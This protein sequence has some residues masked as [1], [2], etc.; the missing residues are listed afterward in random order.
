MTPSTISQPVNNVSLLPQPGGGFVLKQ[1]V[2]FNGGDALIGFSA[3]AWSSQPGP[4]SMRLWLDQQPTPGILTLY[5][6]AGQMHLALGRTWVWCQGVS[7]GEHTIMLE[8]GDTTVTD[9]NDIACVTVWEMGDGCAVRMAEDAQCPAGTGAGLIQATAETTGGQLLISGSTSGWVTQAGGFVT[10]WMP[11]DGGDPVEMQVCANNA[12]Q[13]LAIVP[14]DMVVTGAAE[15]NHEVQ[16]NADGLT[17]TDG[18]DTA[19]LSVVEW[20]NPADAPVIQPINPPLQN[21]P[22]AQ[23]SG[24]G[25]V[26]TDGQFSTNGGTLLI[27]TAVSCWTGSTGVPLYM[28]IQVDGTSVGFTQIWANFAT[29]HMAMVT[30]DL[31]V[32]GV[33][34]G[35]HSL[36]LMAENG[37]NTDQND[38][39]SMT[40]LEF[41]S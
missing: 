41:P 3:S 22:L 39:V 25:T 13:H 18:G 12:N 19:H 6:N 11:F 4:I 9:A 2:N 27:R 10:A 30:N 26:V 23:Q 29:T 1:N 35:T 33:A 36:G 37:V 20:I 31:V 32:T 24:G 8:A 28:G 34:A 21:A 40:I 17:S 16:L 15:G 7:P 38:R 14:T 5:A